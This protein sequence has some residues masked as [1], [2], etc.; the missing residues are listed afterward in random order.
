MVNNNLHNVICELFDVIHNLRHE[1]ELMND[2]EIIK[3]IASKRKESRQRKE[4]SKIIFY[5]IILNSLNKN[6]TSYNSNSI[7]CNIRVQ[8]NSVAA[9]PKRAEMSRRDGIKLTMAVM[10]EKREEKSRIIL[11]H[12]IESIVDFWN[13]L[14]LKT[15]W[16]KNTNIFQ[17]TVTKLKRLQ[18][19]TL[20]AP[21]GMYKKFTEQEIKDTIK[22]FSESCNNPDCDPVSGTAR[23]IF[24]TSLT[25]SD[26]LYNKFLSQGNL[27]MF[28][29]YYNNPLKVIDYIDD[30]YPDLSS[31]YRE[32]YV[33]NVLG[34]IRPGD[35]FRRTDELRFRRGAIRTIEFFR[36]NKSRLNLYAVHITDTSD[37]ARIVCDAIQF[38]VDDKFH[39]IN[40]GWF[41]SDYTFQKRLPVYLNREGMLEDEI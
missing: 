28:L 33:K 14:Q 19:G 41:A 9:R 31:V 23:H 30:K 11:P 7:N 6:Y 24:L 2:E 12:P 25:F 39:K 5:N 21:L 13:S 10:E 8:E 29:Y 15:C 22:K 32:F 18:R 27:S 37:F 26:F 17:E 40:P 34:N 3:L 38:D 16:K 20:L 36:D 35:G 4:K 1:T